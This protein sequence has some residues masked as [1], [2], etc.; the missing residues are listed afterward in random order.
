MTRATFLAVLVWLAAAGA[1]MAQGGVVPKEII[2]YVHKDLEADEL[3][4]QLACELSAVLVAPVRTQ[5]NDMP[6][7]LNLV[8][9]G[10]RLDSERVIRRYN[11][12][13]ERQFGIHTLGLLLIP[14]YLQYRLDPTFGTVLGLP[15]N[16]GVVS[17]GAL[18]SP[19]ADLA[20]PEVRNLVARRA[21][22]ISFRYIAHMAG[23]W[24]RNGCVLEYPY[25]LA[26]VERKPAELCEDDRATLVAAGVLKASPSGPCVTAMAR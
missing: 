11:A 5:P 6:I 15:F 10:N 19:G 3:V 8:A 4:E 2:L 23:L 13:T 24:G 20:Q 18:T 7:D 9:T 21:F 1:A 16:R 25:G 12:Y 17:I 26:G 14:Y 22:K